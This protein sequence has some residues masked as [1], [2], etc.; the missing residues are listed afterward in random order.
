MLHCDNSVALLYQSAHHVSM[1]AT[2][3]CL[4]SFPCCVLQSGWFSL[5][6]LF[7]IIANTAVMAA[8]S[9]PMDPAWAAAS[10]TLNI[11]FT[12]YFAMELLVKLTGL[13]PR[14]YIKD[15]MNQFDALVV[16]ASLVEVALLLAPGDDSSERSNLCEARTFVQFHHVYASPADSLQ[17]A[18]AAILSTRLLHRLHAKWLHWR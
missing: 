16:A 8:A 6:S 9:Y 13:G 10:E 2:G 7:M 17:A 5:L 11:S 1:T 4:T 15:R 14:R 18:A 12:F 3:R